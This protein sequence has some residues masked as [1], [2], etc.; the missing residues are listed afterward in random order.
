MNSLLAV[1]GLSLAIQTPEVKAPS[2][3][4]S[5]F[6]GRWRVTTVAGDR[7]AVLNLGVLSPN[8]V[9]PKG[10]MDAGVGRFSKGTMTRKGTYVPPPRPPLPP[11]TD[12]DVETMAKGLEPRLGKKRALEFAREFQRSLKQERLRLRRP[13]YKRHGISYLFHIDPKQSPM[14]IELWQVLQLP[15][16][17]FKPGGEKKDVV[18]SEKR[19]FVFSKHLGIYKQEGETTI[20]VCLAANGQ[21]RPTRFKVTD[22]KQQVLLRL[23]KR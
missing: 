7:S 16:A 8:V 13:G 6:D 5:L 10:W 12:K 23:T 11:M 22:R 15:K 9:A 1:V 21:P 14:Q 2:A 4:E 17:V 19:E 3:E 18:I 20:L